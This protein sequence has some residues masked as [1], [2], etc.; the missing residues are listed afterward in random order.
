MPGLVPRRR[1][2][3][4]E[5]SVDEENSDAASS[6]STGSKRARYDRDASEESSATPV[7]THGH[8]KPSGA[9]NGY[10]DED[11]YTEEPHQPG[12][13]VRVK[14]NNFVTYTAA[15]FHPGPSLNMVIGPNGTGKSTLVCAICLGLGWSP[16]NLGRAKELGEFVKHGSREAEIEIELAAAK[17]QSTNPVIRRVIKKDGN[18]SVFYINGR[19]STQ[20]EVVRLAKSFAIQIDNLCQFLPQDRVAE[21]AGLTPIDLLRETQRAAA[22]DEMVQWHEQLKDLRKEEKRVEIEQRNEQG[23]LTQLQAKQNATREDV[24]RWHQ[25]QELIM[26]AQ[27]LEKCKPIIEMRLLKR[28]VDEIKA[29]RQSVKQ[30]LQQLEREVAPARE[31]QEDQELYRNTIDQ[32]LKHRK[33]EVDR[34]QKSADAFITKIKAEQDVGAEASNQINVEKESEKER[35]QDTKRLEQA[36]AQIERDMQQAPVEFDGTAYNDRKAQLSRKIR[37]NDDRTG[38]IRAE[39]TTIASTANELKAKM[40]AKVNARANLDSQSGQQ[41]SKLKKLSEEAVTAWRWVQGNR[42]KFKG[43]IFGPPVITC[44][45]SDKSFADALENRLQKVDLTAFTCTEEEDLQ[46]LQEN[47]YGAPN[48]FKEF[49]IRTAP[50]PLAYYRPPASR[51]ELQRYGFEGWLLDFVQGPEPVVAMLCENA[52]LQLT[53][54]T[55]N[56][57]SDTQFQALQDSRINGWI[58]GK[59]SFQTTRRREYG[60]SS[61][62]VSALKPARIFTDKPVDAEEKRQLDDAIR[63]IRREID[64][65]K[66]R[67][68]QLKEEL[69]QLREQSQQYAVERNEVEKEKSAKQKAYNDWKVLP[70]KK[71]NKEDEL[72]RLQ[73]LM[74]D[75]SRRILEHKNTLEKSALKVASLT[76]EYAA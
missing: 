40:Q 22:P 43:E 5:G 28:Q 9:R 10:H 57:L 68:T 42:H 8:R 38:E 63:D 46:F 45:V 61:T 36:I 50:Q 32:V 20:K 75:T 70:N 67:H 35:R 11:E 64:E 58:A 16:L 65:L 34:T 69:A 52:K 66:D 1:K 18:K 13:I 72:R 44:T 71:A 51:E 41:E 6:S 4:P 48:N 15:E 23:L 29:E 39:M 2:R 30:E 55:R 56:Q 27:A 26:K 24:E 76:L 37:D 73:E 49:S 12:S 62:K 17:N 14:L 54:V 53:A 59:E 7:Q 74:A 3:T 31:A 21:F 25:R 47:L 33:P 19:Q 60:A